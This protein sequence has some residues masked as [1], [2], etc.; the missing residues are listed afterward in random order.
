MVAVMAKYNPFGERAGMK[1]VAE[2]EPQRE[3]LRVSRVLQEV[4]FNVQLLGSGNYV[5]QKLQ[6]LNADGLERVRRPS[7]KLTIHASSSFSAQGFHSGTWKIT[8]KR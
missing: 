3:I 7:S 5:L 6:A 2:Q 1:K 8:R 4:E